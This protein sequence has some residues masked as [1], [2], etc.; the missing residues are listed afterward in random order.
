MAAQQDNTELSF[1]HVQACCATALFARAS[2]SPV[3]KWQY[4]PSSLTVHMGFNQLVPIRHLVILQVI[5][6]RHSAAL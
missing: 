2:V 4:I 3:G 5:A 6:E 1:N